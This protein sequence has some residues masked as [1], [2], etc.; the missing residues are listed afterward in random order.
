MKRIV[1]MLYFKLRGRSLPTDIDPRDLIS[2]VVDRILQLAR[3][4][5]FGWR[6][7]GIGKLH[8]RGRRVKVRGARNLS[9]GTS[10]VFDDDVR[11]NAQGRQGLQLGDRVTVGRGATIS[12][13]GVIAELGEHIS[14]G[15]HSAIGAYNTLWGQGGLDIGS[16]CLFGPNVVIVSENHAMDDTH[17]LIREQGFDRAPVVIGDNCWIGANT[18]IAAGVTIG[19]G[20]VVGAGSVVTRDIPDFAVAAGAPARVLRLRND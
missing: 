16:D 17:L 14:I 11:I 6:Y 9:V 5:L 2:V 10:V 13:S 15:D 20:C 18:V 1:G 12:V 19:E 7:A 4:F 8:F 3:G